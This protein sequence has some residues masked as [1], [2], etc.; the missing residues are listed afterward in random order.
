MTPEERWSKHWILDEHGQPKP[1]DLM[2]WAYWLENAQ[3]RIVKQ[4]WIGEVKVSTVFLGLDHNYSLHHNAPPYLWET[5]V[6]NGPMNGYMDRC[7]GN[8][9][10]AEAMH[11]KVVAL[12]KGGGEH[13]ANHQNG[14]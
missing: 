5:M 3:N 8:K 4:E 10:Q 11:E 2:T 13:V 9:E 6:F 14:V 12:V 1:V 7:A